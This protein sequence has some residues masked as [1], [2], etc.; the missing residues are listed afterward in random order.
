M[1]QI[2]LALVSKLSLS[3]FIVFFK[4]YNR[5]LAV[6]IIL[7]FA[8]FFVYQHNTIKK[9]KQELNRIQNNIE[10][11]QSIINND[12]EDKRVL[13]LNLNEYKQIN[14]SLLNRVKE[15]QKKLKIKDKDLKSISDVEQTIKV[16]TTV[17]VKN[18][19]F[20]VVIKPNEL[21]TILISRKDSLLS[22]K[23]EINNSLK[24]FLE[25]KK[26]YKRNYKNF[27]SRLLHFDF[28]K[29]YAYKYTIN[30][31]NDII[32]VTDARV[33]DITK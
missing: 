9:Q 10:A 18:Y 30:N 26:I 1:T 8:A 16:D 33:I 4:K 19:D 15:I 3:N 24:I 29:K 21:T 23:I 31:S 25:T 5:I 27:I 22:N 32:N 20:N 6:F 13:Q 14:D 11:Y 28:K 17:I 7:I 12:K 2:L